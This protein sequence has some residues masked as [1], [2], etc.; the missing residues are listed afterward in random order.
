MLN[1]RSRVMY[2]NFRPNGDVY[3]N[4]KPVASHELMDRMME[5][6]RW[7]P[8]PEIYIIPAADLDSYQ[9]IG[10]VIYGA[11]RA[12][13]GTGKVHLFAQAENDPA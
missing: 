13:F 3:L 6:A 11:Q 2:I 5:A 8:Q 1:L 10:K 4:D 12:G 9:F 7:D